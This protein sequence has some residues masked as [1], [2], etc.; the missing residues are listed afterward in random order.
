MRQLLPD[1]ATCSIPPA[2]LDKEQSL[3]T[4]VGCVAN[5]SDELSSSNPLRLIR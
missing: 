2:D 4:L 5:L 1:Y 3:A